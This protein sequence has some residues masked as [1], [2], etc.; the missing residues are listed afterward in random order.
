[1]NTVFIT[2]V[3]L[4]T[5]EERGGQYKEQSLETDLSFICS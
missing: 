2:S 5:G 4:G 3:D 1:M